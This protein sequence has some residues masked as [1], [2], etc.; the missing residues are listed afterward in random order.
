MAGF[1]GQKYRKPTVGGSG[2]PGQ[3]QGMKQREIKPTDV[4]NVLGDIDEMFGAIDEAEAEEEARLKAEE[5]ARLAEE[6]AKRK[7]EEEEARKK[8][9]RR[10]CGCGGW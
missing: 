10:P 9:E 5:E 1:G 2:L 4:G 3:G 8:K 7:A 6:E